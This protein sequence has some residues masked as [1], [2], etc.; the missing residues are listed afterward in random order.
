MNNLEFLFNGWGEYLYLIIEEI[1]FT[2]QIRSEPLKISGEYSK[3][4]VLRAIAAGG[5]NLDKIQIELDSLD[6]IVI[7]L[8]GLMHES[9]ESQ[10]SLA[11]NGVLLIVFNNL[12]TLLYDNGIIIRL[13]FITSSYSFNLI[14]IVS[15][16]FKHKTKGLIGDYNGTS[17]T[18][19]TLSNG[20]AVKLD[21]ENDKEIFNKFGLQWSVNYTNSL[22]TYE[23]SL[24]SVN[25]TILAYIPLFLSDGIKF[26]N[27]SI[28][29]IAKKTCKKNK[30]CLFDI[31]ATG[32]VSIGESSIKFQQEIS[33]INEE[34]KGKVFLN[35]LLII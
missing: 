2:I 32:L 16:K 8:N 1:N 7:Y 13:N 24:S 25:Y 35:Y 33:I 17:A 29:M 20:T 30:Q 19:F 5:T 28:E 3:G 31:S 22:F 21:P 14:T 6:N 27:E 18:S 9:K 23:E 4:T 10:Y 34:I 26:E 11:L 15:E 12:F